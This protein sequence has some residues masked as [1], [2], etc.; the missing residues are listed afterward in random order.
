MVSIRKKR[1]SYRRLLSQLDDFDKNILIG[2]T[3]SGRQE[4][5]TVDAGTG[6]R[7]ITVGNVENKLRGK[8]NVVNVKLWTDVLPKG[9]TGK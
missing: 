1:Q 3:V 7:E 8:K 6:D 4:N 2:N 5:A 9:L